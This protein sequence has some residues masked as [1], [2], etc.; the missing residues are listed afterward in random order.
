MN[1][2]AFSCIGMLTF[3]TIQAQQKEGKIIYQRT[4]QRQMILDRGNGPESSVRTIVHKFEV[5]FANNQ[6][7]LKQQED[8]IPE[9]EAAPTGDHIMIRTFG[10]GGDDATYCN[11]QNARKVQQQEFF[12]KT[13]V[14]T[15]SIRS[16]KWKL[17]NETK[18][19]LGHVCQKATTQEIAK[20]MKMSM[21]NGKMERKETEDT[22]VVTAWFAT[23]IPVPAAPE[24]QGQ[25]PGAMLELENDNG[26]TVYVAIEISP[27]ADLSAIKEPT[28]GKKVTAAEFVIE[29]NKM[30]EAMNSRNGN[31]KISAD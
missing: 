29:R 11:F 15:D 23:D 16:G 5:D 10:G 30:I 25:L 9:E 22:S 2:L 7:M 14:I 24:M 20:H 28:K 26:R 6:M 31:M 21:D 12:D 3:A 8:D 27:K 18:S 4:V 13:F 1:K 19:I 17:S